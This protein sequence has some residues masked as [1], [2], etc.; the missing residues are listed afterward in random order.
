[1]SLDIG[2]RWAVPADAAAELET[3]LAEGWLWL[4]RAAMTFTA[5]SGV[6]IASSLSVLMHLA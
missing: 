5:A 2:V 1:M 4:E 6:L 3:E